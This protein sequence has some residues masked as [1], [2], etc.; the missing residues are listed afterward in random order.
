MMG[1]LKDDY[2]KRYKKSAPKIEDLFRNEDSTQVPI[3]FALRNLWST[4]NSEKRKPSDYY[5]NPSSMLKSQEDSIRLHLKELDDDY[6]PFLHPWYGTGITATGFGCKMRLPE[7]P[8]VDPF[9]EGPVINDIND[10]R[11]LK[12]P[13]PRKDGMMPKVLETI[14]FMKENSDIP[15]NMGDSQGPLNTITLMCG[16][17]N[18]YLWM[19][20]DPKA[21]HFLFD[22]VTEAI[23]EWVKIQKEASGEDLD[24]LN[25]TQ[26]FWIPKGIGIRLTEDDIVSLG[27][28][29]Y[30][31][32]IMP[33]HDRL[34]K[35]FGSS[36]IHFCGDAS[37][38][39]PLFCD[40]EKLAVINTS[41]L[42][43][44]NC[45]RKLQEKMADKIILQIMDFMP[46][47]MKQYYDEL[48]EVVDLKRVVLGLAIEEKL[49]MTKAGYTAA[50][51]DD[52]KVA[53]EGLKYLKSKLRQKKAKI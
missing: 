5:T 16:H 13:D 47:N 22:I 50:D 24:E 23:T 31:E 44:F 20:D 27:P 6:I 36:L 1:K 18:L 8:G 34:S 33:Y 46:I 26:F 14:Q 9:T 10:I 48:L 21:V 40:L 41:T 3:F 7:K 12:M 51:F 15:V 4:G 30:E 38:H 19:E 49:A 32:F 28:R 11:K 17:E 45:V 37:Q 2:Q 39:I 42:W 25:G 35:T 43:D 29:Q 52:I 53:K